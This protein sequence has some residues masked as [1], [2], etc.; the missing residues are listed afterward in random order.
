MCMVFGL[1]PTSRLFVYLESP[2]THL[3]RVGQSYFP[4]Q[5]SALPGKE[6]DSDC[7]I[8]PW[9]HLLPYSFLDNHWLCS[10]HQLWLRLLV[11]LITPVAT[12]RDSPSSPQTPALAAS[13][14]PYRGSFPDVSKPLR[15]RPTLFGDSLLT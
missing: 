7:M 14:A 12:S 9:P 5:A 8:S 15:H 11:V 6:T 4:S 10:S 2:V 3:A 1:C 13:S